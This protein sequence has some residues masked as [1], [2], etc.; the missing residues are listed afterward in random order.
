LRFSQTHRLRPPNCLKMGVLIHVVERY[1]G[2]ESL[3]DSAPAQA[4]EFPA[5]R[6]DAAKPLIYA[7]LR[8]DL[9]VFSAAVIAAPGFY[10]FPHRPGGDR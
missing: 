3:T 6:L 4:A 9:D 2:R 5:P 10:P 8:D 1:L 7:M